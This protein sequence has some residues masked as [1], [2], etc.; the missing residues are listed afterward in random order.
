MVWSII[1]LLGEPRTRNYT[2]V[3]RTQQPPGAIVLR[4]I[5]RPDRQLP[6]GVTQG[7]WEY[8]QT[9]HIAEQYDAY[10]AENRLFQFDEQVLARY[11]SRPGLVVDLGCGTGRALIPL[12]RRGCRGLGVDLSTHMLQIVGR[13]ARREDLPIGLLRANLVELDCIRSGS[14]DYCICMFSTLGMIRGGENRQRALAHAQRILR[15]QGLLVLHV[16]N[17]WFAVF[18]A[19][20]RHWLTRHLLGTLFSRD[21]ERGD[22]FFDY[23]GIPKMYLHTFTRRELVGAIRKAGLGVEELIPLHRTRQRPLGYPWLFG[24]LRANGWIAVCRKT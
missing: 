16:H 24:W 8:A 15:P 23:R 3:R 6:Q 2:G 5:H 12:A 18:D 4:S 10:F 11:F 14:V 22:K 19:A 13:K 7:G 9:R 21:V 17:L 20:G 1:D